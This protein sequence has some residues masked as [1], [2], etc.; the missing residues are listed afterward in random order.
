MIDLK[1]KTMDLEEILKMAERF[2]SMTKEKPI[3]IT[4]YET[5]HKIT[6]LDFKTSS[7]IPQ[8]LL[9]FY[10]YSV[11]VFPYDSKFQNGI[12]YFYNYQQAKNAIIEYLND[13]AQ[14]ILKEMED[15]VNDEARV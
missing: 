7:G 14:S 13:K 15:W 10:G 8:R 4:D 2:E 11:I 1:Y 5:I 12:I 6:Q 3:L 9:N